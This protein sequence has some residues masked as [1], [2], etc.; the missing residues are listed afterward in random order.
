MPR[1]LRFGHH[2]DG[3]DPAGRQQS[4]LILVTNVPSVTALTGMAAVA[5]T[6]VLRTLLRSRRLKE[7]GNS[8]FRAR[9]SPDLTQVKPDVLKHGNFCL[10]NVSLRRAW[11]WKGERDDS[12]NT[13]CSWRGGDVAGNGSGDCGGRQGGVG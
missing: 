5:I 9:A 13:G 7:A 11:L 8:G 4:G 1:A 12:R 3:G 6:G 10:K 2:G